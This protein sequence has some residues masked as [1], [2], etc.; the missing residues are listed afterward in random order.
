MEYRSRSQLDVV[1]PPP[2]Y[3]LKINLAAIASWFSS[4]FLVANQ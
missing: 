2:N 3:R 4:Q 1:A